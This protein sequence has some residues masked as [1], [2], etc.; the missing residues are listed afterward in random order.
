MHISLGLI[1]LGSAEAD[2]RWGGKLNSRVRNRPIHI[3]KFLESDNFGSSYNGNTVY[4]F[5]S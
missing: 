5:V 1:S 2:T 4:N 3:K